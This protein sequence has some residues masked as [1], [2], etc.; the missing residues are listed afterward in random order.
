MRSGQPSYMRRLSLAYACKLRRQPLGQETRNPNAHYCTLTGHDHIRPTHVFKM[1]TDSALIANGSSA[2]ARVAL[3]NRLSESAVQHWNENAYRF[4]GCRTQEL[5]IEIRNMPLKA[6]KAGLRQ[7][8]VSGM[9]VALPLRNLSAGL[10]A[11]ANVIIC[12]CRFPWVMC[13]CSAT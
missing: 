3:T 13:M 2:K 6:T 5:A 8:G 4:R 10:F 11:L 12:Y 7:T 9:A 1:L